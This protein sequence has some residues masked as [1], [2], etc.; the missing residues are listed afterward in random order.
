MTKVESEPHQK[1]HHS[2]PELEQTNDSPLV[3]EIVKEPEVE[4]E[5]EPEVESETVESAVE[6]P[7]YEKVASKTAIYEAKEFSP[8]T[9]PPA[10]VSEI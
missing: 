4:T 8:E 9:P 1:D 7:S 6:R 2:E 10:K 5:A 3:Q